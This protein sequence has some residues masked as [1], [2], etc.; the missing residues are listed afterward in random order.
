MK[1]Q[2]GK[3]T[4]NPGN[5][6]ERTTLIIDPSLQTTQEIY[7]I[8][9]GAIVPRP[10]ALVSSLDASG[11]RN[12]APFSFFT[13][14]SANPP[15]ICF[16]PLIR[17]SSGTRKDT[18]NNIE[19]TRE[20][21]VHVVPESIAARVNLASSEVPPEIDE[22]SLAG[23]TPVASDIVKPVR[24]KE[25]PVAM[26]CRLVEVVH[27]SPRPMGGSI[28]IGEVVRFHVDDQLIDNFRI[29]PSLLD[30]VGRMGGSTWVRTTDRFELERPK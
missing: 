20:F 2:N 19:A 26:E 12:L 14:A 23:L 21:V 4:G 30:A 11:H 7:K 15:I 10:I 28:V 1:L 22:F 8:L 6:L 17:G 18:L 13:A 25:S 9:V 29:D 3:T 27:V 16:C 24:V 5:N